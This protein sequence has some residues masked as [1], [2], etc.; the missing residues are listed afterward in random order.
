MFPPPCLQKVPLPTDRA[1]SHL[2]A[3]SIVC[4]FPTEQVI[5]GAQIST[6]HLI[7]AYALSWDS[8]RSMLVSLAQQLLL[9]L[10]CCTGK[11]CCSL[12]V[13]LATIKEYITTPWQ[14]S[15]DDS[16]GWPTWKQ[17]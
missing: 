6:A 11:A 17:I 4:L 3:A 9:S 16:N 5:H 1:P 14:H 10:K 12:L 8:R 2:S 7:G 15:S 13:K